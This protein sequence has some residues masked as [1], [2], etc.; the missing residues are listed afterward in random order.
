[1]R[2]ND[3]GLDNIYSGGFVINRSKWTRDYLLLH[4]RSPAIV[5][6]D[7]KE[8]YVDVGSIIIYHVGTAQHYY[9][10]QSFYN[11]DF[12]HFYL[13]DDYDFIT[14]LQLPFNKVIKLPKTRTILALMENMYSEFI[15]NNIQ[16]DTTID[17]MLKLILTKISEFYD[18]D[19]TVI[20]Y[21]GH[22]DNLHKLKAMIYSRPEK[23]WKVAEMAQFCNLSPSHFQILYKQ[24]F[25]IT[26]INDVINSKIVQ[27]K[28]LLVMTAYTIKE[29]SL[30][31]G[32]HNYE[33][34]M[35]QF[36]KCTGYT[37]SQYRLEF[38]SKSDLS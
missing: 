23:N 9:A 31:C 26:C 5:V 35:R 36:K 29:I 1:M 13:D 25:N 28:S 38:S 18:V 34:F 7:G 21:I 24:A 32:Y 12:I 2:I 37:P 19:S 16:R 10:C 8:E 4:F 22:Y 14:K 30:L 33:Y 11:D 27:A 15:S 17:L 3:M 6:L 20:N